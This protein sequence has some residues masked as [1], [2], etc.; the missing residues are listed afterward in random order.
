MLLKSRYR[1]PGVRPTASGRSRASSRSKSGK[2]DGGRSVSP[3]GTGSVFVVAR[4]PLRLRTPLRR[5]FIREWRGL[6][7]ELLAHVLVTVAGVVVYA[8]VEGERLV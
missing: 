2:A 8:P 5:L 4:S 7:V 3:H 6:L 1:K